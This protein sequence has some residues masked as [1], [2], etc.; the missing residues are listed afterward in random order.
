MQPLVYLI[1][2]GCY[3]QTLLAKTVRMMSGGGLRLG[4]FPKKS[5][6]KTG[7]S[8]LELMY[9]DIGGSSFKFHVNWDNLSIR[10]ARVNF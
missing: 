6:E 2:L 7:A 4:P 1:M 5:L 3:A 10:L 9:N 8:V